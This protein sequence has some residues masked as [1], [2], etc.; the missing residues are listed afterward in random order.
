VDQLLQLID[1]KFW[2]ETFGAVGI[3]A[4]IFAETGL[5]VGFFLPGD[6]LLFTAGFF[7]TTATAAIAKL[8][9][10][11]LLIGA[12]VCA[13]LGAQVGHFIG[14]KA[15]PKLFARPDSRL[16]KREYIEKA[17]YYFEKFGPARAVLLA[18]FIPIVRT[19]LNP[20]AGTLGMPAGKFFLWNA[21]GGVIWSDGVVLLGH[22]LGSAIPGIDKYL[23]PAILVIV[24]LSLIPVVREVMKARKEKKSRPRGRHAADG[25]GRPSPEPSMTP[26]DWR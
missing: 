19:F 18:R 8:D 15:G 24:V 12:P 11:L 4:I 3:L 14:M 26:D 10:T 5:M 23:L 22:F 9:I 7:T 13:I 20:L 1:A 2:I 16:F 21:L 17:E 6:S 25:R